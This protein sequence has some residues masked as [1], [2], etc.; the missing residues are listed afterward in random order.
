VNVKPIHSIGFE[1][2]DA[3]KVE[4]VR[5]AL[6]SWFE[7]NAR[8]LPWRRTRDPWRILEAPPIGE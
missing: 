7:E 5:N 3:K 8:D 4:A 6:I 1:A 2:D